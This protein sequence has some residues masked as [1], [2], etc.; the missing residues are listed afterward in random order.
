MRVRIEHQPLEFRA[1][2]GRPNLRVSEKESL[3][4]REASDRR[5]P[6]ARKLFLQSSEGDVQTAEIRDAFSQHQIAILVQIVLNLVTLELCLH[7][8]GALIEVFLVLRRPPIAQISLC[9]EL[10]ALIV[11]PVRHFMT[12]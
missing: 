10:P 2:V 1:I 12:D 6:L 5:W 3:L 4:R 9:I 8:L 11:E 7:A